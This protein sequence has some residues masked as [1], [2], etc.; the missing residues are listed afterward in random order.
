MYENN[1]VCTNII[2]I[3]STL[4][5]QLLKRH[6][7]N[8]L[9]ILDDNIAS[10]TTFALSI[11]T[12][13]RDNFA[14]LVHEVQL[15][16]RTKVNLQAVYF[17]AKSNFNLP[18]IP[19]KGRKVHSGGSRKRYR[20]VR[21]T[22]WCLGGKYIRSH[23]NPRQILREYLRKFK[24]PPRRREREGRMGIRSNRSVTKTWD[25][26]KKKKNSHLVSKTLIH[27]KLIL[28]NNIE[29]LKRRYIPSYANNQRLTARPINVNGNSYLIVIRVNI[30]AWRINWITLI[31]AVLLE[32]IGWK[33]QH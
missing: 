5:V 11:C 21:D 12:N 10:T 7:H 20:L 26:K 25:I 4:I 13:R 22:I 18:N 30:I 15:F 24:V 33:I 32:F 1:R 6:L 28:C 17:H 8:I 14:R 2:W 27:V 19:R 29:T 3:L 9:F 16:E 23:K 31:Y